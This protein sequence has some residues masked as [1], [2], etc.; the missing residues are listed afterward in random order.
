MSR[1]LAGLI[2]LL[3]LAVGAAY[4]ASP[5]YAVHQLKQAAVSGDRDRL[6][7]LVD[8]PAVREDLRSQ[9]ESKAVKL[10]REAGGIG[11]PLAMA[12]GKLG[13]KVSDAAVDRLVTP[14]AIAEL[15]RTGR[16]AREH[17][18]GPSGKGDKGP[19]LRYAYLTPD[20]FKV[21]I[22]PS[23]TAV[24]AVAL[25]MDRRGLFSWRVERVELAALAD[26]D[27][28]KDLY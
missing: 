7:A 16:A 8:F 23:K 28:V 12:I 3:L 1:A 2:L 14:D 19:F 25:I 9:T 24:G 18:Q 5:V 20:R 4:A 11:H 21:T 13:E 22:A 17:A 6:E 27:V 26:D 10:A 15:V